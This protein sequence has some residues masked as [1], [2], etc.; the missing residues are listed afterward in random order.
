MCDLLWADPSTH[1]GWKLSNR[2]ISFTFGEDLSKQ[3]NYKNDLKMIGRA[4]QLVMEG[5]TETHE[6]NV[7]TIFSA[8]NYCYYC[9]NEGAVMEVDEGLQK[10]Y[11]QYD[12]APRSG[13]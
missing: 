12:S 9:K 1:T 4:H 8:P 13:K 5:Y 6:S 11:L 2:G 3:F 10:N 7:S